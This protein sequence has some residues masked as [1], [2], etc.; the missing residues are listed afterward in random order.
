MA[1]IKCS[2]CG[3]NISDKAPQCPNCGYSIVETRF[4]SNI[5][6]FYMSLFS[7]L[8]LAF[9]FISLFN[10]TQN[11]SVLS[12]DSYPIFYGFIIVLLSLITLFSILFLRK[13]NSK[14]KIMYISI[15]LIFILGLLSFLI[16]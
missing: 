12:N 10:E 7:Y 8:I 3:H 15:A 14:I 6:Y 4:S 1:L 5:S 2:K 11:G 13:K 9:I 16:I